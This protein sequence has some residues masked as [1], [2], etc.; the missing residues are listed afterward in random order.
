[1]SDKGHAPWCAAVIAANAELP[2]RVKCD[3]QPNED[4]SGQRREPMLPDQLDDE[5]PFDL[6]SPRSPA[7]EDVGGP[8]HG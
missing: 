4:P 6:V 1:M 5:P 7:N 3:C 2:W 8:R